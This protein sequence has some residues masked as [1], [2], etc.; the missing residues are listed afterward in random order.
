MI[1]VCHIFPILSLS[2]LI[3][4]EEFRENRD[5]QYLLNGSRYIHTNQKSGEK[6]KQIAGRY[7][8]SMI[9]SWYSNHHFILQGHLWQGFK[10]CPQQQGLHVANK[11][12]YSLRSHRHFVLPK[13]KTGRFKDTF[14]QL[15][16][17]LKYN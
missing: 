6:I 5:F 17:C 12:Q 8:T 13:W 7:F 2:F 3:H 11:V 1:I 9:N 4:N 10:R 15:L 14:I 16:S